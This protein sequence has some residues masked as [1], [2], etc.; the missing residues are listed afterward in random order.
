MQI[1]QNIGVK[2]MYNIASLHC[3]SLYR[4]NSQWRETLLLQ[5]IGAPKSRRAIAILKHYV[6]NYWSRPSLR[7]NTYRG[8]TSRP[9][10]T[11]YYHDL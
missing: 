3:I 1:M 9:H 4:G 11:S 2:Y 6:E 5:A 10:N 8:K 7:V